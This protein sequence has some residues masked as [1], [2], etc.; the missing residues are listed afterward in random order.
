MANNLP[1]P[2]I[3]ILERV[4]WSAGPRKSLSVRS[5]GACFDRFR[6]GTR[7]CPFDTSHLATLCRNLRL[8][9]PYRRRIKRLTR[10]FASCM[11]LLSLRHTCPLANRRD[12]IDHHYCLRRADRGAAT[13]TVVQLRRTGLPARAA[14]RQH[15]RPQRPSG[16]HSR[17]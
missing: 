2:K 14:Q 3:A 1:P 5:G 10:T 11:V 12:S 13:R 15:P 7:N 6:L 17:P 8:R 16:G 4:I 9:T